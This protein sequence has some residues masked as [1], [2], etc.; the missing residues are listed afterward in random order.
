V[1]S[2]TASSFGSSAKAGAKKALQATS[3]PLRLASP[4]S[5]TG[6]G[7]AAAAPRKQEGKETRHE[8]HHIGPRPRISGRSFV[9]LCN[10]TVSAVAAAHCDTGR[11]FDCYSVRGSGANQRD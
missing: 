6:S 3:K 2:H 7:A 11:R 10:I 1:K 9:A 4:I 5:P 8:Q